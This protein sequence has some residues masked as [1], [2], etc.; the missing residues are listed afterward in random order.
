MHQHPIAAAHLVRSGLLAITTFHTHVLGT[1]DPGSCPRLLRGDE[2]PRPHTGCG[3]AAGCTNEVNV[4]VHVRIAVG[5]PAGPH[6]LRCS[7]SMPQ[8]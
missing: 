1:Q 8:M 7:E 6:L 2:E 3:C 4:E 5:C